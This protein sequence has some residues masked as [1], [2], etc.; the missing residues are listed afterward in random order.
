MPDLP[1]PPKDSCCPYRRKIALGVIHVFTEEECG[2]SDVMLADLY[3]PEL[4]AGGGSRKPVVGFRWCP[5]CG[6]PRD[7]DS[8]TLITDVNVVEPE[9]E[10]PAD[11]WKNGSTNDD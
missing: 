2:V 6:T 4:S 3:R 5:W 9:E 1:T 11:Y 10:D 8:E 7:F